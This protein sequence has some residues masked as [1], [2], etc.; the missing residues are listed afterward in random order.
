MY[1]KTNSNV[2]FENEL[3]Y[4]K[5]LRDKSPNTNHLD[6]FDTLYFVSSIF[7]KNKGERVVIATQCYDSDAIRI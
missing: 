6:A 1:T 2:Y 4:R 7:T 5:A 3:I